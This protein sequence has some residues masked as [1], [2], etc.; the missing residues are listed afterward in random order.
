MA[1]GS[2]YYVNIAV[3]RKK[4]C[5]SRPYNAA[6]SFL[7]TNGV[8]VQQFNTNASEINLKTLNN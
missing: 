1:A 7:Y 5:L 3:S 6:N 8:K 4:I 2:K